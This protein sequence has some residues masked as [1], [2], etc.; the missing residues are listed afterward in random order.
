MKLTY[1]YLDKVTSDELSED[2]IFTKIEY[3]NEFNNSIKLENKT[4]FKDNNLEKIISYYLERKCFKI[5]RN[6]KYNSN[7]FCKF[8]D[9]EST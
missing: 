4:N 2:K 1:Q 9:M 6:I 7:Q 8:N 5:R 3:L